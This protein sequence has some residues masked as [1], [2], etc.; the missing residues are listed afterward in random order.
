MQIEKQVIHEADSHKIFNKQIK[1]FK[2]TNLI[3]L[4]V[5]SISFL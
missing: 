2:D 5:P 3:S 1:P 4:F